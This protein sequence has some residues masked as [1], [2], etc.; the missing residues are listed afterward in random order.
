MTA[1]L[2]Q[3]YSV[4]MSVYHKEQ[5]ERFKESL[6]SLAK[7]TLLPDQVVIVKDG[8]LTSKL[9]MVLNE[10]IV[11]TSQLFTTTVLNNINNEGLAKSLQK[12]LLACTNEIVARADTDDINQKNRMELQVSFLVNHP[13]ITVVGSNIVEQILSKNG[14]KYERTVP[15]ESL[16]IEKMS[17]KRNPMNHMTVVFR[18]KAV[19]SVGN[20]EEVP[21]FEDYYLWTKL[22]HSGYKLYNIPEF[23][24]LAN[25]DELSLKRRHGWNYF[26]HELFFQKKVRKLT[27]TSQLEYIRNC[28]VRGVPRIIPFKLFES[29]F[30]LRNRNQNE[31][32][33]S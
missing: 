29:Q 33:D 10:F 11:A 23:L 3:K 8:P 28:F 9:E 16:Q 22:I 15:T 17:K 19:L 6:K 7:Q 5:P 32:M 18:K 20:Y 12:G 25:F 24:V 30:Y 14:P 26:K 1:V 31:S 27:Y 13:E 21:Y 2:N 4:L